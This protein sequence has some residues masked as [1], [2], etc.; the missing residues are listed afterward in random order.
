MTGLHIAA[1]I[2]QLLASMPEPRLA[3]FLSDWPLVMLLALYPWRSGNLAQK[4]RLDNS[5]IRA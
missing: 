5:A 3:A 2:K 1:Q 4:A